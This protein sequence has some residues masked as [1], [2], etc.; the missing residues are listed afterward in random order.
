MPTARDEARAVLAN[1]DAP[2][3]ERFDARV[4]LEREH[5]PTSASD[6]IPSDA[7]GPIL[8]AIRSGEAGEDLAKGGTVVPFADSRGKRAKPKGGKSDGM[9]SVQ[10]DEFQ[11]AVGGEY[12]E[13]PGSI[14]FNGLR[15]M[16]EGTPVLSA[17]IGTRIRQ[18]MRFCTPS[19][20]G[21]IGFSIRHTDKEHEANAKDKEQMKMLTRFFQHGGWEFTP[22]AR[23]RLKRDTFQTFMAKLVRDTLTFDACPFETEMRRDRKGIDG[24]YAVDGATVR[25]CTEEG[26]QGEDE[27]YA[28]QVVSGRVATTYTLDQLVYEVRNPR[29]DVR[30]AGYGLGETELLVR[31]VTY[32]LNS[33]TY[34]ADYFDKN[35]IPKGLLQVFGDYGDEDIS[36]FRRH[37][38]QMLLGAENRHGLPV[39]VSKDKESGA[40]FT[41]FN[42]A[43]DEMAFS[44][45]ITF[46]TSLVC[47]IYNIDPA[48]IGF[49]SF[50]ANKSSLSGKDT[51]EKLTASRDKGFRPLASFFESVFTD[52]VVADFSPD[53]C[54]RFEGLEEEDK[55]RAWEAKKLCLTLDEL[56]AEEGYKPFPDNRVGALPVNPALIGPVMELLHP[57]EPEPGDDFGGEAQEKEEP[58]DDFGG[59]QQEKEEPGDDF[60]G[61]ERPPEEPGSDFGGDPPEPKDDFAKALAASATWRLGVFRR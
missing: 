60:G 57:P 27:V 48:E 28:L 4:E 19:E 59:E 46:L 33:T 29:T 7:F 1:P 22:R 42:N 17:V 9:R 3:G 50:S 15:N 41:E 10:L 37:W 35:T 38:R 45:W 26:Y 47:A 24:M 44:K 21:G 20:D 51:G 61:E 40:V 13:K 14:D 49:E 2:E 36:A 58:G 43:A 30:L 32:L 31:T 54:F 5:R 39:L 6:L 12:Y 23:K 25:L 53:L 34:N 52:F 18:M 55:D 8:K 16:V 11:V 56:R